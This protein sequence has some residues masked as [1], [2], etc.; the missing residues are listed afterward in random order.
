LL[1]ALT[2]V[3][4]NH[5]LAAQTDNRSGNDPL[6]GPKTDFKT[7]ATFSPKPIYLQPASGKSAIPGLIAR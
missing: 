7:G 2:P 5:L 4:S 6:F 3:R 1:H